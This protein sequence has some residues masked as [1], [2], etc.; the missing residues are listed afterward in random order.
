MEK[1]GSEGSSEVVI[2]KGVSI[3]KDSINII[4]GGFNERSF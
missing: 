4:K 3:R 1:E 2:I